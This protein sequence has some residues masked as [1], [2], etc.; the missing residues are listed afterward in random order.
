MLMLS[1][2]SRTCR[3]GQKYFRR[4]R[5]SP[6]RLQL[7]AAKI[8]EALAHGM[9]GMLGMGYISVRWN[10]GIQSNGF[11]TWQLRNVTTCD[12]GIEFMT[13]LTAAAADEKCAAAASHALVYR[14]CNRRARSGRL[15]LDR[16][17]LLKKRRGFFVRIN[18]LLR[19]IMWHTAAQS[20]DSDTFYHHSPVQP[21]D[22][23]TSSDTAVAYLSGRGAGSC[24]R[25]QRARGGRRTQNRRTKIFH[26]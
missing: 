20:D 2:A 14:R 11:F 23:A 7:Q 18:A 12:A 22:C 24:P 8:K 10:S 26:D 17:C 13:R 3:L 4:P 5:L 16:S 6:I 21:I 25:T 9:P 19:S 1:F 15:P